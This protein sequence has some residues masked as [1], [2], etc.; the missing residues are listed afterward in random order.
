MS[1]L[2]VQSSTLGGRL[3]A[4]GRCL[5]RTRDIVLPAVI[6]VL[7]LTTVTR[8]PTARG[9]LAPFGILLA[10]LGQ[11]WRALCIGLVYIQ[12]GGRNRTPYAD[13]LVQAGL[14]SVCR[15]PLYLGNFAIQ[16]GLLMV[17][18]TPQ[19]YWI[20]V[21]FIVWVYTA[22]VAAEEQFL[23][24]KFGPAYEVYCHDVQRWMPALG[25]FPAA[26][27]SAT[28]D[29]G[30]LFRKEY[31]ATAAWMSMCCALILWRS[32]RQGPNDAGWIS[33]RSALIAWGFVAFAY[34]IVRTLKKSNRLHT[35]RP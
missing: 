23:R 9:T 25:R 12:R 5:F 31:G 32:Y 18:D 24:A 34:L 30:R 14:F 33:S 17:L 26:F 22:I 28:F 11:L 21:P 16:F 20:G 6:L 13:T 2:T 3:A 29:W 35:S 15:N 27:R 10:L 7:A 4:T 1:S 8:T 19:G